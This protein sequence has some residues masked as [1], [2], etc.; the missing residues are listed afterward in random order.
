MAEYD[1]YD[2]DSNELTGFE[3]SG[4]S[5]GLVSKIQGWVSPQLGIRFELMSESLEIYRPDGE[6]FLTYVEL[7]EQLAAERELRQADRQRIQTLEEKLREL[8]INPDSL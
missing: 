8:G 4:K 5:L 1:I 7:G 2:P 6:R 3:R